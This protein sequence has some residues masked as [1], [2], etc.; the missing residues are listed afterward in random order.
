MV[1]VISLYKLIV[2]TIYS[3]CLPGL[4]TTMITQFG[5]YLTTSLTMPT[6]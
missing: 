2:R 3:H 4:E 1:L 5:L 6:R